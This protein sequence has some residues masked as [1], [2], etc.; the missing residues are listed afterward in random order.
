MSSLCASASVIFFLKKTIELSHWLD[1]ISFRTAPPR[2]I[3]CL[4]SQVIF[5]TFKEVFRFF[6]FLIWLAAKQ[7]FAFL[8]KDSSLLCVVWSYAGCVRS[9]M[10][11]ERLSGL[12]MKLIHRG[13]NYMPTAEIFMNENQTG[14]IFYRL[15]SQTACSIMKCLVY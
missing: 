11:E 14:D 7:L 4:H 9:S 15:V 13:K 10:I 12:A 1:K 3:C 5:W 8:V 2:E 6:F